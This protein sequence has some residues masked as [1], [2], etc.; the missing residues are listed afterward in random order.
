MFK[1][2]L[3][4]S[5]PDMQRVVLKGWKAAIFISVNVHHLVPCRSLFQYHEYT[6]LYPTHVRDPSTVIGTQAKY[7]PFH[8]LPFLYS[9][10]HPT[11]FLLYHARPY[12]IYHSQSLCIPSIR[13]QDIERKRSRNHGLPENRIPPFTVCGGI[14]KPKRPTAEIAY[15]QGKFEVIF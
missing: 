3:C 2:I 5:L 1:T 4:K 9:I 15:W 7:V 13:S 12:P 10:T 11:T 8:S 6:L 14:I